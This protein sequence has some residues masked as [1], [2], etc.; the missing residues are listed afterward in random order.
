MYTLHR[1]VI[2]VKGNNQMQRLTHE[3]A[4]QPITRIIP[5]RGVG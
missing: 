4:H 2:L 5:H 1:C 3:Q